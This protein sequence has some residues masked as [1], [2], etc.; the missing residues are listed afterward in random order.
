MT[1]GR[2][3]LTIVTVVKDD[4][5]GLERTIRSILEQDSEGI[6]W[7]VIDSSANREETEAAVTSAGLAGAYRWTEPAGVYPAMNQGVDLSAGAYTW[8]INAGDAIAGGRTL[9]FVRTQLHAFEPLWL[10]GQVAFISDDGRRTVPPPFDYREERR[11][12][13][14]RGRFAPHQ[15]TVVSTA[16]LRDKGGFDTRFRIAADYHASLRLALEQDPLLVD[17]VLAEFRIGGLSTQR[18]RE[19]LAEFHRARREVFRPTGRAAITETVHTWG[20]A[21]RTRVARAIG[22]A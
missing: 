14:A 10:I 21:G 17:Q 1:A 11:H 3:W 19:A 12:L 18:W 2:P 9:P 20:L 22:R 8:F 5:T 15:G 16:W 6:E 7:V 13:F 4:P